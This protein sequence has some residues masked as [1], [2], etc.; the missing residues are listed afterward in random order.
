MSCGPLNRISYGL[1]GLNWA[2]T[3]AANSRPRDH[4]GCDSGNSTGCDS[5]ELVE[6]RCS[7]FDSLQL[8][9]TLSSASSHILQGVRSPFLTSA[10]RTRKNPLHHLV[11]PLLF[12]MF[13]CTGFD[14]PDPKTGGHGIK[15][16]ES[17]EV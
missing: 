3:W 16:G 2:L 12:P 10:I 17:R 9:E 5:R 4:T 13:T 15:F 11:E 6:S 1:L 8:V 7:A 14:S